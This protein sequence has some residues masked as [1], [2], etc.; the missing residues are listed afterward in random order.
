MSDQETEFSTERD[1]AKH[2]SKE[3]AERIC[4]ETTDR[5]L[6]KLHKQL[7]ENKAEFIHRSRKSDSE[8]SGTDDT[9][10]LSEDSDMNEADMMTHSF[11]G[12][13]PQ[14]VSVRSKESIKALKQ[15]VHQQKTALTLGRKLNKLNLELQQLES[16]N[17]YQTL[18]LS[19]TQEEIKR[20][21]T[22]IKDLAVLNIKL[23]NKIWWRSLGFY[24][25]AS[26]LSLGSIF[27]GYMYFSDT[28]FCI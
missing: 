28:R 26:F 3:K 15:L 24:A 20:L 22:M 17:H 19:N 1:S 14:F 13:T 7:K 18:E 16:R 21:E 25:G 27:L 6:A 11:M 5:E 10:V 9:D 12:A 8:E 2:L 23:E 4:Q